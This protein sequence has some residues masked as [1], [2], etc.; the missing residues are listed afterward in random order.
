[1]KRLVVCCFAL[2]VVCFQARSIAQAEEAVDGGEPA[3]APTPSARAYWKDGFRLEYLDPANGREYKIRFRVGMEFRYT[4]ALTDGKTEPNASVS[5][6]K[7]RP[8]NGDDY[9]AFTLRRFRF[10]VDG[11]APNRDWAYLAHVQLEPNSG[12]NLH[13]GYARWQ[14]WK[15]LRVQIGRMKIPAYG[16]EFWNSAFKLNGTDRTIFTGDSENDEDLFGTRTYDFPS[17]NARLRVGQQLLGNGFPAGGFTLYRSQGLN[18]DGELDLFER[19]QFLAYWV[20]VF[21]GRDTRGLGVS[22]NDMLGTLRVGI[23]FLPGSDPSGP[24]GPDGLD[25]YAMQGDFGFNK[26]PLGAL[27][28]ST[29]LDRQRPPTLYTINPTQPG[30]MGSIQR[31]HDVEN[32][33]LSATGLFRWRGFSTDL[34]YAWEEFKQDPDGPAEAIWQRWATRVNLGYFIVPKKWEV[35]AKF[36]HVVRVESNDLAKSI[37]SGLALVDRENGWVVEDYLE[38]YLIGVN[39]YLDGF[40]QMLTADVAWL[41][42]D[43]KPVDRSDAEALLGMTPAEAAAQFPSNTDAEDDIRFRIMYQF[44]F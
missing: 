9:S 44:L 32:Y 34:E 27:V 13:D 18:L 14:H 29:F 36:A 11:T 40:H 33:G 42:A 8:G 1:M 23:N 16:L 25:G 41:R 10:Y 28:L 12:V 17:G 26:Q 31:D 22:D 5:L 37:Q 35:T 20:G 38:Q 21:N 3:P 6:G 4:Y 43:F 19:K 24:L 7:K 30:F 39:W 15:E 2:L